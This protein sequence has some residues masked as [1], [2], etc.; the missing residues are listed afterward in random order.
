[1]ASVALALTLCAGAPPPTIETLVRANRHA[2]TIANG[3]LSGDGGALVANAVRNARIVALGEDHFTREVPQFGEALCN[4]MADDLAALVLETGPIATADLAP[5]LKSHDGERQVAAFTTRYPNGVAFLDSRSDS[6]FA[7]HCAQ[8]SRNSRYKLIGVDQEFLG[9]AGLIID[10]ILKTKLSP[11]ARKEMV[12]LSADERT[13]AARARGTGDPSDLL[14][15]SISDARIAEVRRV[16]ALGASSEARQMFDALAESHD[17][18]AKNWVGAWDS[19]LVRSNLMKRL[20]VAQAPRTGRVLLKFGDFHLYK[21]VG[22]LGLRDLGNYVAELADGEGRPSL[23]I[24]ML[25]AQGVRATFGGYGRPYGREPFK[26]VDDPDY[27]WLRPVVDS[28]LPGGW[29]VFDLRPFRQT[30]I[31]DLDTDWRRTINGYDLLVVVP[32]L[33]PSA[34]VGSQ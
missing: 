17:I 21:G 2:L 5:L 19:N 26:M 18:Y 20:F 11:Q 28:L 12:A 6:A 31:A 8:V 30:R 32:E 27:R 15:D 22:P 25:G 7:S 9:S 29:T 34:T 16:L 1:M 13:T 33:T 23:H 4:L 10:H 24:L 14:L 3:T